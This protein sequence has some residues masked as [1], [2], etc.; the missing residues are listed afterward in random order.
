MPQIEDFENKSGVKV[1]L[2]KGS[3][4]DSERPAKRVASER[5]SIFDDLEPD[6]IESLKVTFLPVLRNLADN[7]ELYEE[8]LMVLEQQGLVSAQ[9]PL[10]G[11]LEDRMKGRLLT[12]PVAGLLAGPWPTSP[13]YQRLKSLVVATSILLLRRDE[14]GPTIKPACA[15]VRLMIAGGELYGKLPILPPNISIAYHEIK[16]HEV[17]TQKYTSSERDRLT[18]CRI[19]FEKYADNKSPTT[20]KHDSKRLKYFKLSDVGPESLAEHMVVSLSATTDD[21]SG[22]KRSEEAADEHK[23]ELIIQYKRKDAKDVASRSP[24]LLKT[25]NKKTTQKIAFNQ[26][27]IESNWNSMT[28]GEAQSLIRSFRG[29][30]KC[31]KGAAW[32]RALLTM[33]LLTGRHYGRLL[34]IPV[35]TRLVKEASEYWYLNSGVACLAYKPAIARNK[36]EVPDV[37]SEEAKV[38]LGEEESTALLLPVPKELQ[39]IL[40]KLLKQG[41]EFI[42]NDKRLEQIKD[43]LSKLSKERHRQV[44]PGRLAT[45]MDGYLI[46]NGTDDVIRAWLTGAGPHEVSGI[47]YTQLPAGDVIRAYGEVLN[48][49][50]FTLDASQT[51]DSCLGSALIPTDVSLKQLLATLRSDI[52]SCPEPTHFDSWRELHALFAIYT[53]QVLNINLGARPVKEPFGRLDDFDLLARLVIIH[54]KENQQSQTPRFLPLAASAFE[55][56]KQYIAFLR[57]MEKKLSPLNPD[58]ATAIGEVLAAK[59]AVLFMIEPDGRFIPFNPSALKK[60]RSNSWPLPLNWQRHF[61]RTELTG[62]CTGEVINGHMGHGQF[63]RDYWGPFSGAN[64]A[65]LRVVADKIETVLGR[66]EMEVVK[67]PNL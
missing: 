62:Q 8:L 29:K 20:R 23:S 3:P 28:T 17:D 21:A 61:L 15:S 51:T 48:H 26:M 52:A 7:P 27:R 49:F 36:I 50:G 30:G 11:S 59:H 54:D 60:L 35:R 9:L 44:S 22:E 2:V 16:T 65:D 41:P 5:L 33:S 45:F 4:D 66:L 64:M 10:G 6:L 34:S 46:R 58:V 53:Y 42:G 31:V 13:A 25:Y 47:H 1:F 40:I 14:F 56:F 18:Y 57:V 12:H 24:E 19:L 39:E 67:C 63:A 43:Y 32:I 55:Q 38:L 37:L